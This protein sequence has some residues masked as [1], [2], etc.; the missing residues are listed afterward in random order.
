MYYDWKHQDDIEE[1]GIVDE[2][3]RRM[4][5]WRTKAQQNVE[6]TVKL[7]ADFITESRGKLE[8]AL[9]TKLA[10]G[11]AGRNASVL[12]DKSINNKRSAAA[13]I[14]S[15]IKWNRELSE[16]TYSEL[17]KLAPSSYTSPESRQVYLKEVSES[18]Q[19]Q[20]AFIDLYNT[21]EPMIEFVNKVKSNS[22]DLDPEL[23]ALAKA[24]T[25]SFRQAYELY[26]S[27]HN[28]Q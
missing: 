8:D 27:L 20:P 28:Y 10:D 22:K 11:L 6:P 17:W 21:I 14:Y 1:S 13:A 3:K 25:E 7:L 18:L 5:D 26:D 16:Q 15:I 24:N 12:Y 9:I 4:S 19:K 2:H 23:I